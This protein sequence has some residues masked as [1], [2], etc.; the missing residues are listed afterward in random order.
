WTARSGDG[1]N[2]VVSV[3][4]D[5]GTTFSAPTKINDDIAPASHGMHSLA[6]GNDGTI[7]AA[8]L[9]ERNIH[10]DHEMAS[11]NS[12]EDEG[13]HFVMIDHKG[14]ASE[15]APE[16]NSNVFFAYSQ[17]GGKS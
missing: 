15:H 9:D 10:K 17:D 8:W 5:G 13:F 1:T 12:A 7:Y 3:S 2:Y 4:H 6:I 16:P 14:P 11:K